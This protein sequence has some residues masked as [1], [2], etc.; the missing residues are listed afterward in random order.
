MSNGLFTVR[1][2]NDSNSVCK[3]MRLPVDELSLKRKYKNK[4]IPRP[5]VAMK[6]TVRM[7]IFADIFISML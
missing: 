7:K 1:L 2:T 6:A 4:H 3:L 5:R